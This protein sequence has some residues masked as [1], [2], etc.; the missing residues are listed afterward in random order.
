M[1]YENFAAS[2]A[3]ENGIPFETAKT[4]V[5]WMSNEGILDY[6]ILKETYPTEAANDA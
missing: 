5:D 2:L 1:I 3:F 6:D 4:I